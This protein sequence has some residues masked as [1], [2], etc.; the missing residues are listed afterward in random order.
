[1][2]LHENDRRQYRLTQAARR[3]ALNVDTSGMI[4]EKDSELLECPSCDRF[5]GVLRGPKVP[6]T[7]WKCNCGSSLYYLQPNGSQCR[8]CGAMVTYDS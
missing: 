6:D 4:S 5:F 7:C 8:G 1:M 3:F 2:L